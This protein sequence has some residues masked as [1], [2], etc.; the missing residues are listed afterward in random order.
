ME[1]MVNGQVCSYDAILDSKGTPLYETK[2]ITVISLVDVVNDNL[3]SVFMLL[4]EPAQDVLKAGRNTVKAFG[5][6][7]V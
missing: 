7:T 3:D 1:V 6:K 2:N 4:P 5:V